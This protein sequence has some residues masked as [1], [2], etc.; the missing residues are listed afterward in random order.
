MTQPDGSTVF[1]ALDE[2]LRLA[3]MPGKTPDWEAGLALAMD[4]LFKEFI[5]GS[6]EGIDQVGNRCAG[7]DREAAARKVRLQ[8]L[9]HRSIP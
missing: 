7:S 3:A 2:F 8:I 4:G 6:I 9:H 5:A 1:V